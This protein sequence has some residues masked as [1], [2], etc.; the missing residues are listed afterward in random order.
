MSIAHTTVSRTQA[1]QGDPAF[2]LPF[3]VGTGGTTQRISLHGEGAPLIRGSLAACDTGSSRVSQT[4]LSSSMAA[5]YDS[6]RRRNVGSIQ[7]IDAAAPRHGGGK[8]LLLTSIVKG[9]FRRQVW[10]KYG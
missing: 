3:R 9:P 6:R 10:T 1:L 4:T 8:A 2:T 7:D 5:V